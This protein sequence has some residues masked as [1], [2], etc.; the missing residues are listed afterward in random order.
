M[1]K[2]PKGSFGHVGFAH[3]MNLVGGPVLTHIH[4]LALANYDYSFY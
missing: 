3:T 1:T 4:A 2:F